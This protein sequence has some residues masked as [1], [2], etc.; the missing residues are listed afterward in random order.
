MLTTQVL[1]VGAQGENNLYNI[2]WAGSPYQ[3]AVAGVTAVNILRPPKFDTVEGSYNQSFVETKFIMGLPKV[4]CD[5]FKDIWYE[6]TSPNVPVVVRADAAAVPNV[7]SS[8][9]EQVIG[10]TDAAYES[11]GLKHKLLYPHDTTRPIT[12]GTVVLRAGAPGART[13]T[14]RS[15]DGESLP[16]VTA[17]EKMGNSGPRQGDGEPMP[18][19]TFRGARVRFWN[20]MEQLGG[21][22]RRWD[23]MDNVRWDSLEAINF[24]MGEL[25]DVRTKYYSAIQQTVLVGKGIRT[26]LS[27]NRQTFAT[28]GIIPQLENA[29]VGVTNVTAAGFVNIM[30]NAVHDLQVQDGLNE[31]LLIGPGRVLDAIGHTEKAERVRYQIG[32]K[33]FDSRMTAYNYWGHTVIP[34]QL[35]AMQ[36]V[37]MYGTGFANRVIL[38]RKSQLKLTYMKNW[39]MFASYTKLANNQNVDPVTGY[40]NVEAAWWSAVFG[41]RVEMPWSA[42]MFNVLL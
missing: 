39:P 23:P 34:V 32:D 9:V 10:I 4:A 40:A 17:G 7:G 38:I 8:Y 41:V 11:V 24:K 42:A 28:N 2:D 16:A 26:T 3:A 25:N 22:G 6:G 15:Y 19:N 13:I 14:V 1:D 35:N 30:R 12:H 29:N 36:D 5:D 27:D 37:G 33:T 31:W 21:F 20:G 18:A